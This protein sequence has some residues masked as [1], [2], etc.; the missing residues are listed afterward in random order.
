MRKTLPQAMERSIC[1]TLLH[2]KTLTPA[3]PGS[4]STF[5]RPLN[6][7][8]IHAQGENA[9]IMDPK[10]CSKRRSSSRYARQVSIS[11]AVAIRSGRYLHTAHH[12]SI[13][14]LCYHHHPFFGQTGE[15]IR[16]LRRQT[17]ESLVIQLQDG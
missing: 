1:P 16:R 6:A 11:A 9:D 5:S 13:V 4:G 8:S 7:L 14:R 2:G 3:R 10:R 12:S 17:S 15:I